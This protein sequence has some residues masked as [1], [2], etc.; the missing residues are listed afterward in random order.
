MIIEI[1]K[2][3]SNFCILPKSI[4]IKQNILKNNE[5]KGKKAFYICPPDYYKNHW[6]KYFWNKIPSEM[7]I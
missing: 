2:H 3:K 4:L 5:C 7:Y 1:G 6:S